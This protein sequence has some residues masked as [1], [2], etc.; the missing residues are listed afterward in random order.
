MRWVRY[1]YPN[2]NG[3]ESV[4]DNYR[5]IDILAPQIY[6]VDYNLKLGEAEN[7]TVLN[8]ADKKRMDVMPLVVNQ[9]FDQVLMWRLLSDEDAQE[10]LIDDLI[11]EAKDRD[12]IGWQFDFENLA[13]KGDDPSLP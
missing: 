9:N 11:D 5:D 4:K 6:T 12:F 1:Y 8:F 3:Y 10:E 2:I 13:A 7:E